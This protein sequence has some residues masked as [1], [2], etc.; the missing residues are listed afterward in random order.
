MKN[1]LKFIAVFILSLSIII[2][3]LIFWN[4]NKPFNKIEEQAEKLALESNVLSRVT[5]SYVYNG[6]KPYITVFGEDENG[7]K[8]AVF[9]PIS[10]EE[11]AIQEVMLK[12]GITEKQALAL[13]SKEKN[14]KKILHTKLGYESVG[15]VWEITYMNDSDNINY[16]YIMFEDGQW[17]K[18]ILNL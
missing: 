7:E 14:I 4:A 11:D 15:P 6:S 17:W 5:E 18:R 2:T 3:I 10:L 9:V 8:K 12:E 13:A 16:V 1:W